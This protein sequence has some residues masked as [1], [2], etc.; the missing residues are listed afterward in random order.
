MVA[1]AAAGKTEDP[2]RS[3]NPGVEGPTP[4]EGLTGRVR[5]K[6]CSSQ[7]GFARS[8]YLGDI[9]QCLETI[10]LVTMGVGVEGTG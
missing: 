3:P 4:D 7:G 8:P 1:I 5:R 6:G 9:W 10:L 2:E